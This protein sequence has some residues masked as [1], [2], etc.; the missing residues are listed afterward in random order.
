MTAFEKL[1]IASIVVLQYQHKEFKVLN[2]AEA[3]KRG[4][5]VCEDI[6]LYTSDLWDGVA[7]ALTS[8]PSHIEIHFDTETFILDAEQGTLEQ[9]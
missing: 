3:W 9:L 8:D 1:K 2:M 6:H 4:F 5:D 7:T